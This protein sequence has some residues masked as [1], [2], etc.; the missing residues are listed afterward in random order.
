MAY[1]LSYKRIVATSGA[2]VITTTTV[3]TRQAH[4]QSD[5]LGT[6][7]GEGHQIAVFRSD[8]ARLPA[9]QV[10]VHGAGSYM[11]R[12]Q[13]VEAIG[14][15]QGGCVFLRHPYVGAS[16]GVT[17][18]QGHDGGGDREQHFAWLPGKCAR[19]VQFKMAGVDGGVLGSERS[20]KAELLRDLPSATSNGLGSTSP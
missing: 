13:S 9:G 15:R 12:L 19:L 1:L 7:H 20:H 4:T 10:D 11:G 14:D 16:H 8:P 18:M 2:N 17:A 6:G 3:V 5:R